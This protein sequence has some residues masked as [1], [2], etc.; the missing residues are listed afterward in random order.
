MSMNPRAASLFRGSAL[1]L[2]LS[3]SP[4]AGDTAPPASSQGSYTG[5]QAARGAQLAD[6]YCGSCHDPRRGGT[7]TPLSG[8][9]F[10]QKWGGGGRTADDL[11]Y[12]ART[13]M[14]FGAPNS[15]APQEYADIV[16][17]I[18]R[19]NGAPAGSAEL[20]PERGA[21]AQ[22]RF[23]PAGAGGSAAQPAAASATPAF[24]AAP[25]AGSSLPGGPTQAELDRADADRTNWLLP[26]HG[27]SGQR[28]VDAT[29]ITRDNVGSLAPVCMY[30]FGDKMTF[31]TNPVVYD[32]V[33]YAT[34]MLSTVAL[35]ATTCRLKWRHDWT[36]KRPA[37]WPQNRGVAIKEGRLVRGTT[38]GYLLALDMKTGSVLWESAAA[39]PARGET[40]TMAPLIFEDL[41]IAGPAGAENGVRGWIGAFR[42]DNGEPVWRFSTIPGPGEPGAGTWGDAGGHHVGGGSV[43]A[44][45]AL[46]VQAGRLYVPVANPAPDLF[47]DVRPGANL[48]TNSMIVLEARTGKLIWHFQAVPHDVRDWDLT[49]ASPLFS[50][51]I[52]GKRRNLV[53]AGGKHGL[54][55]VLD[56]DTREPLYA[57]PVTTRENVDTP[58]T[59]A[60]IRSC[61]GMLGGMQWNGPAFNPLTGML[62]VPAVDWCG[63]FAKASELRFVPGQMYIGG[64]FTYDP[65][66]K[67]RGW[68]TAIDAATGA[69]RWRYES[70]RPMLAAVTTTAAGLVFTGE[71]EGDFLVLDALDGRVLYRFPTGGRLNGG[72]A[73]F[74]RDG[75]QFVAVA[76]GNATGFWRVP[77]AASTIIVFG[78]PSGARTGS[79]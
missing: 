72:I 43:W 32:G 42:L 47:G 39:D 20:R 28:F 26:N 61:P 76:S 45:A 35:E 46:D 3:L 11:F 16:A 13:L 40:F 18:L 50:I 37:G 69:V 27:Y 78:L 9:R 49:Q 5:A 44:A 74:E 36:P 67:S 64:S 21:L 8:E 33:L 25:P 29:R 2:L 19:E 56:R 48:Y 22:I 75:R 41:V 1:G 17:Y 15:L 55:H 7:A 62:Y 77:P 4:S 38:D 71:L 65:V 52:Q 68:L 6:K 58:L 34:T 79:N 73:T 14:P 53:A 66:E 12:I 63:T 31:H 30:Q 23:P 60:G 54:L 59:V 24:A 57:V 51:G 10:L 70:R